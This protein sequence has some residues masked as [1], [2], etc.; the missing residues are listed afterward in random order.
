VGYLHKDALP[1]EL[2]LAIRTVVQGQTYLSP[3]ISSLVVKHV[4]KSPSGK[5]NPLEHI[6]PRQRETLQLITEGHSTKEIA[7]LLGLSTKTVEM[8]RTRLMPRLSVHN[9]AKPSPTIAHSSKRKSSS[10]III[11]TAAVVFRVAMAV[12]A[13]ERLLFVPRP[14]SLRLMTSTLVKLPDIVLYPMRCVISPYCQLP[15]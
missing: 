13:K 9:V 5:A 8:H 15:A 4:R 12:L 3:A 6:R 11:A 14:D 2:E 1:G 7:A 10:C